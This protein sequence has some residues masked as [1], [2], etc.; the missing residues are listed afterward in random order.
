MVSHSQFICHT[1]EPNGCTDQDAVWVEDSGG[2]REP[3]VRSGSRSPV[4]RGNFEGGNGCPTVKYRDILRSSVQKRLNRSR[5]RLGGSD[6]PWKLCV[7][8]GSR[9][10]EGRCH[11]EQRKDEARPLIK[12]M[13]Y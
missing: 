12:T 8:W 1:S 7:R 2:P 10:A 11:G 4:G 13:S 9:G 3:C 6:G 5:C